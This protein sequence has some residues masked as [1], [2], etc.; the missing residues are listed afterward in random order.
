MIGPPRFFGLTRRS[1]QAAERGVDHQDVLDRQV[2]AAPERG[3]EALRRAACGLG[4]EL[5]AARGVVPA[6]IGLWRDLDRLGRVVDDQ[7]D[8]L[9]RPVLKVREGGEPVGRLLA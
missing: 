6:R 1:C 7:L 3:G 4:E 2:I 9:N 8:L 5:E